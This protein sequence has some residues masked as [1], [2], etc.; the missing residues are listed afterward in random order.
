MN[1]PLTIP[2]LILIF[3]AAS[4]TGVYI[5]YRKRYNDQV[6][7]MRARKNVTGFWILAISVYLISFFL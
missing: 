4:F 1:N 6:K 3:L 2:S 7:K 5:F